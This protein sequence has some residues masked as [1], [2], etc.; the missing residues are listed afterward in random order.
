[1]ADKKIDGFFF[2]AGAKE[3]GGKREKFFRRTRSLIR[4][5]LQDG[6]RGVQLAGT[7]QGFGVGFQERRVLFGFAQGRE[8]RGGRRRVALAQQ[9][10]GVQ[11]RRAAIVR[12]E[13]V[14]F[15]EKFN[16]LVIVSR[17]ELP[18]PQI[19]A[20]SGGVVAQAF[21]Q[22]GHGDVALAIFGIDLRDA[23]EA[24]QRIVSLAAQFIRESRGHELFDG[25]FRAVLLLQKEGESRDA[26]RRL[27]VRLQK[28][29]VQGERPWALPVGP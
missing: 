2:L 25:L 19:S 11:Q 24:R 9:R 20:G 16:R 26:F 6:A 22:I 8:Q 28:A 21:G 13:L 3:L 12:H 4:H 17:G 7:H 1:M 15:R 23:H 5:A 29:R 14:R 18:G 27:L 10:L